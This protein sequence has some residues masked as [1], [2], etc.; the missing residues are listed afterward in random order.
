EGAPRRGIDFARAQGESHLVYTFHLLLGHHGW[1]SLTP[2]HFLTLAGMVFG[3]RHLLR[4]GPAPVSQPSRLWAALAAANVLLSTVVI[5]FYISHESGNYGGV[6]SGARWLIW[7]TPLWLLT[8]VP[9]VD[10]LG[11][12]RWG[13]ALAVVLLVLSVVSASYPTFNPW[14]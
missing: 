6:S 13:R 14:R 5:V 2:I 7:L 1:F 3:I 12:R 9:V 10:W 8:M 11:Q 4:P